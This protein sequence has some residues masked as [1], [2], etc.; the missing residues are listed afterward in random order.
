MNTSQAY[1]CV[2]DAA[3][4]SGKY[5]ADGEEAQSS[6]ET[7]SEETQAKLWELSA[8]LVRLDG[9]EPLELTPPAPE[10]PPA[11]KEK[12]KKEKKAKKEKVDGKAD[13]K[14]D[15]E[16]DAVVENGHATENGEMEKCEEAEEKP[17]SEDKKD[18]EK[19]EDVAAQNGELPTADNK[20]ETSC[21]NGECKTTADAEQ[22]PAA[23]ANVQQEVAVNG[24]GDCNE[25]DKLTNGLLILRIVPRSFSDI[26]KSILSCMT[27]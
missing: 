22:T 23:E 6:E 14:P 1:G 12:T 26:D 24:G 10:E 2:A 5:I 8:R 25:Q 4:L 18:G 13:G 7:R 19:I 20:Q 21:S 27:M 15:H 17:D 16:N 11:T 3:D 9:Y